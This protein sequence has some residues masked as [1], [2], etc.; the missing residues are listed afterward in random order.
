VQILAVFPKT[1]AG[2]GA[3]GRRLAEQGSS[4]SPSLVEAL[5]LALE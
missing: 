5:L 1:A 2:K 4:A 3:S